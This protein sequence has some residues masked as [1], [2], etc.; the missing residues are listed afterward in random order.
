MSWLAPQ[1]FK[2]IFRMLLDYLTDSLDR[3]PLRL[4]P[5]CTFWFC[6]VWLRDES[7]WP[8]S[9]NDPK[10]IAVQHEQ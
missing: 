5:I 7:L 9:I 2:L 8:G 4:C 10:R 1:R 6:S 3:F